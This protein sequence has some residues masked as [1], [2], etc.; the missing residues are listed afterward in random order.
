M[1]ALSQ[2]VRRVPCPEAIVRTLTTFAHIAAVSLFRHGIHLLMKNPRRLLLAVGILALGAGLPVF[3]QVSQQT[4]QITVTASIPVLMNLT[5]DTSTVTLNF[6]QSDYAADGTGS[7]EALNAT[8][9]KVASNARWILEV[10]ADSSDFSYDGVTTP[11][12]PCGDLQLSPNGTAT[13]APVT[14]IAR[15]LARGEAGGNTVAANNIPVSYKLNTT[16]ANDPP[17][18]YVLTLTYT[19]IPQ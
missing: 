6:A 7:K 2:R 13:Y 19:L 12:K 15:E 16:I 3:A 17:G 10:E 14:V 5:V 1:D 11:N 9:L 8:T 18:N 4:Q